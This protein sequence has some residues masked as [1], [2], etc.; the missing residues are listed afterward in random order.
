MPLFSNDRD[1]IERAKSHR[2]LAQRVEFPDGIPR[3]VERPWTAIQDTLYVLT[4][5]FGVLELPKVTLYGVWKGKEGLAW[6][7]ERLKIDC[8]SP[9]IEPLVKRDLDILN[10]S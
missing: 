8:R 3:S 2:I 7:G 10:A 1:F 4:V 5:L 9:K 6:Q